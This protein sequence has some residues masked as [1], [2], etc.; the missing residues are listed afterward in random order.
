V[1]FE[2]P[3]RGA[4]VE[5]RFSVDV[6][7]EVATAIAETWPHFVSIPVT[8]VMKTIGARLFR[9]K[10]SEKLWF[11]LCLVIDRKFNKFSFELGWSDIDEYPDFLDHVYPPE[12]P[13]QRIRGIT[14]IWVPQGLGTTSKQWKV[15]SNP[16]W[17][18]RVL[19]PAAIAE[20]RA[21]FEPIIKKVVEVHGTHLLPTG[22]PL[23][24]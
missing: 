22:T 16:A 11:F 13:S 24:K 6:R 1:I 21:Y 19:V 15:G 10:E 18:P 3:T 9:W 7:N 12:D 14:Q 20:M 2:N 8:G 4:V 17:V 23:S 5:R